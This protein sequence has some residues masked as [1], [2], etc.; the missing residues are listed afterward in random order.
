MASLGLKIPLFISRKSYFQFL[1][2]T[3]FWKNF[4]FLFYEETFYYLFEFGIYWTIVGII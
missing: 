1:E 4:G 2:M 3:L